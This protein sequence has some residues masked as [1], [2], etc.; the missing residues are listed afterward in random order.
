MS[1]RRGGGGGTGPLLVVLG[2]GAVLT[3]LVYA[4]WDQISSHLGDP[5]PV[6]D[7]V[8]EPERPVERRVEEPVARRREPV[9]RKPEPKREPVARRVDPSVLD[10]ERKAARG[11]RLK[12][13]DA[14][15]G[16]DFAAAAELFE[17]EA[18]ALRHDPDGAAKAKAL[19]TKAATF[20]TLTKDTEP[21]PAASNSM[22]TLKM[23]S[24]NDVEN[25]VLVD[26]TDDAYKIARRGM[27]FDVAR[28]RVRAVVRMTPEEHRARLLREFGALER[29]A[30]D[31]SGAGYF[32]LA[33][34]AFRDGL[35]EKALVYL[36]KAYAK[37]GADLP[38]AIRVA[39]AKE[40]LGLAIWCDSTGR[41]DSAKMYCRK[42][43]RLYSGL[44]QQVADA[45]ELLGKLSKPVAVADY[46]STV[47]IKVRKARAKASSKEEVAPEKEEATVVTEKVSSGSA[48]NGKLMAEI[49]KMFDEAMDHY[50]K[51]RPGN[52]NSNTHLHKAA[53]LF[54][55]V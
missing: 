42:V 38:R 8:R 33:D 5:P 40:F 27:D 12:A 15:K 1:A 30:K 11:I 16:L 32:A 10:R 45:N 49:N 22:V 7:V 51:G 31:S 36:E 4:F 6:E 39:E 50:V 25:V 14:L 3:G 23:H 46:K 20:R 29:K 24:G 37:D 48:K 41:T 17:K 26:E 55:K 13:E 54:D 9:E 19:A 34:R 44:P 35:K 18:A 47:R 21:N 2:L 53:A 52:P 28:H 43:I